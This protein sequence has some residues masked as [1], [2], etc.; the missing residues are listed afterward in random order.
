MVN[1]PSKKLKYE[2][3]PFQKQKRKIHQFAGTKAVSKNS[4]ESF[5]ILFQRKT[6]KS[7]KEKRFLSSVGS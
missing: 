6:K 7:N 1:K 3:V 5:V 4:V 2:G